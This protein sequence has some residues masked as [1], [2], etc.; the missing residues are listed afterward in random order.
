MRWLSRRRKCVDSE[1]GLVYPA[2]SNNSY[3][4]TQSE[5]KY[6][7]EENENEEE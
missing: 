5:G 1:I 2:H 3:F 7:Q 6:S 4:D